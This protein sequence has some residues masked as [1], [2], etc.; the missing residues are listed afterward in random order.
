MDMSSFPQMLKFKQKTVPHPQLL[1][2]AEYFSQFKFDV[3]HIS[4]KQNVLADF[5]SRP[6]ENPKAF[7]YKRIFWPRPIMM[8]KPYSS[9]STSPT[10][11]T[12]TPNLHPEY[13]PEVYTLVEKNCFHQK[14][15]DMM[16][17]CQIQV[18]KNFGGLILKPWGIHLDYP[19]IHPLRFT[20]V[21]QPDELKWF[22]WYVTHLYHIA[23]QFNTLELLDYLSKAIRGNIE[24]EQQN[25]FTFLSW[26]H[27]LP[28]WLQIIEQHCNQVRGNYDSYMIIIFYKPQYFVKFG[29]TTQLNSF[30]TYWIHKTIEDEIF[31]DN[32]QYRELQKFL[33]QLNRIIPFEIWP[34]PD[35]D[36]PYVTWPKTYTP[37]HKG[38]L[39]ALREYYEG[40]PDPIEWS[41]DYPWQYSQISLAK[42]DLH[43]EKGKDEEMTCYSE[44]SMDSAQLPH[45][46]ANS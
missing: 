26:F 39:K 13:P 2:W 41:Q 43:D 29:K 33:C 28:Q 42:I 3:R 37:Y 45:S 44:D 16:F 19:F 23:I 40:I 6:K 9:S 36:A 21:E 17:E 11:Y 35:I 18:F 30:P 7:A 1:R 24:P 31:K 15:R 4:R 8:Y 12:V 46:N 5:F 20:F 27:P 22:L 32:I 25:F 38:I 10:H 14:A 34:P